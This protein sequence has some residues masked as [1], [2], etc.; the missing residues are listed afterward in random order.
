VARP[1]AGGARPGAARP[2]AAGPARA[3]SCDAC[4]AARRRGCPGEHPLE[5]VPL[6]EAIN[7]L[8]E[9]RQADVERARRRAADLA[10]SL[11]TPLAAL[12]A[13][14]RRARASGAE[15]AADGL[16]GR[17][18]R[19]RRG[20]G[21]RAGARPRRR[22]RE[23]PATGERTSDPAAIGEKLVRV[24]ERTD[25]G[26]RITF[27]IETTTGLRVPVAPDVTM[28]ILGA[29]MENAARHAHRQVRLAG[30]ADGQQVLLT[31]EDDGPG[32]DAERAEAALIRGGRLDEAGAGHGLG[33]AIVR[34]LAEASG[35]L[36]RM[37]RSD[38]GGLRAA[39]AWRSAA[40]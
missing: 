40:P 37:D 14:S 22:R 38:L 1:V 4:A 9:A 27:I 24:L 12:S 6:V 30:A 3:T 5:I 21:V 15:E 11:K 34:D 16:D 35:A 33:L 10:H 39:I 2:R 8:A 32:L 19:R 18:R 29:L 13:Q 26:E 25:A 36:L 28:E 20:A 17:Y 7:A 31:I 23:T